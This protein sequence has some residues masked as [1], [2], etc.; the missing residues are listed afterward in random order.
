M[1]TDLSHRYQLKENIT[2]I[3]TI[4]PLI[5]CHSIFYSIFTLAFIIYFLIKPKF[6]Q[7]NFAI[8]LES[9]FILFFFGKIDTLVVDIIFCGNFEEQFVPFKLFILEET[10]NLNDKVISDKFK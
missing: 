10:I 5:L 4:A 2:S 7:D 3:T 1:E 8:F 9:K 6:S